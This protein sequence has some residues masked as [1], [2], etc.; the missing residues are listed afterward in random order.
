MFNK[1]ETSQDSLYYVVPLWEMAWKATFKNQIKS[2]FWLWD[3]DKIL[4]KFIEDGHPPSTPND[5]DLNWS[6]SIKYNG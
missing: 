1:Q 5:A 6:L 2:K 4:F 3:H